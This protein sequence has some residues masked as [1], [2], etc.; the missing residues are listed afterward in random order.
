MS[1]G[2]EAKKHDASETKLRKQ[3]E[4]G[5][6]ANS[7][8]S[9]GFLACALGVALLFSS[10]GQIWK[11]M[12]SMVEM[13]IGQIN[14]PFDEARDASVSTLG[15]AVLVVLLPVLGISIVAAFLTAIIYNKGFIFAMKPITP[16][17][18]RVSPSSGFKRIY[19]RRGLIETPISTVRICIWLAFAALLGFW[20]VVEFTGNWAC[21]GACF[22]NRLVPVFRVLII[23]A[24]VLLLLVAG[25]DMIIQRKL[26]LH[27]QKM[28]DT[29]RKKERKDQFGAPEI[30]QE[31]RRRMREADQPQRKPNLDNATMCFFFG[32][33]AVAIEFRPPEVALPHVMARAGTAE[34][35]QRLRMHVA[36]VGWPE[37]EHEELARAGFS[38]APGDVLNEQ[39]FSSFVV[40]VQKMFPQ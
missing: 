18:S 31:R 10:A 8:E 25:I 37:Q 26:F 19:G 12:R 36:G 27:E 23:G 32:D 2:S 29:E 9:A 13:S 5:S 39:A 33:I 22:A 40:A 35:S 28:T 11:K 20:P 4:K 14:L 30:R 3:R 17:M 38:T 7:H 34:E 24:I 1:G 16:Q 15:Q 21:E 6:V